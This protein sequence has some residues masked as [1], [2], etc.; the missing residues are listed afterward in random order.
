[1]EDTQQ[2]YKTPISTEDGKNYNVLW[3]QGG[4]IISSNITLPIE[5]WPFK[6]SDETEEQ[7]KERINKL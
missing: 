5:R 2:K 6:L 4:K 7:F 3:N 1:M